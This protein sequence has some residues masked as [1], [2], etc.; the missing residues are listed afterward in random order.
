MH[1]RTSESFF[2]LD[3]TFAFECDGDAVTAGRGDYFL[4]PVGSPHMITARRGGGTLL[5]IMAPAG[6]HEMFKALSR[7]PGDSLRDPVVR[8]EIS[9]RYDSVPV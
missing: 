5:A 9:S 7:L 4:V 8:R 3:G 1:Q 6:L 2:V